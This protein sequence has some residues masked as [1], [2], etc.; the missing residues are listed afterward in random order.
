MFD[1]NFKIQAEWNGAGKLGEGQLSIREKK[2]QYSTP[3]NMGGKV[4]VVSS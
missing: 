4:V 2:I 1:L 3:S